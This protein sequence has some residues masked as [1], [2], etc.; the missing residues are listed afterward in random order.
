M[1]ATVGRVLTTLRTVHALA[2]L[3]CCLSGLAEAGAQAD[4]RVHLLGTGNPMPSIER[5]GNATL[6]QAGTRYLLVDAGRGTFL[7]L[8]QV[9]VADDERALL[10][11]VVAD[12]V[13]S[14]EQLFL[15]H[16]HSDH[17]V[18]LPDLWLSGWLYRED[19]PLQVRGPAGTVQLAA[20]LEKAFEF[21]IRVRRDTGARL[22]GGGAKILAHDVA[23]GVAYKDGELSVTA[24]RVDHGAVEP[25]YAYRIDFGDRSLVIS[26]D[27]RPS[28]SLIDAAR[29][30]D[31]LIHEVI[32]VD[33][34]LAQDERIKTI[35]SHHTTARQAGRVFAD[36][37]PRLAV[38]SHIVLAGNIDTDIL[39]K[40]AR[41]SWEGPLWIGA[42]LDTIDIGSQIV[43]LR[44]SERRLVVDT[45]LP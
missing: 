27:T 3:L 21:D 29:S 9:A 41:E 22:P 13:L 23:E 28:Q 43:V 7:R 37:R 12:S 34:A 2:F 31:V 19:R 36:S 5:Y 1:S 24:I 33:D 38:F 44:N 45:T 30:A 8:G 39:E 4:F 25:A 11:G 40:Q 16:L 26:G 17:I 18:G 10:P 15:T 14:V 6:V 35:V 42:D 20:H 32:A